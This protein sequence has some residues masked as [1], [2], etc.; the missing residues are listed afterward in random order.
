MKQDRI[1]IV[2]AGVAGINAATKLVDNGYPGELTAS[3]IYTEYISSSVLFVTGS[4]K[5]G[6]ETSDK[7]EFTGSVN[8]KDTLFLAGEPLGNSQLNEFTAS[9]IQQTNTISIF[10]ASVNFTTQSLN[11]QTGSQD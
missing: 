7:H 4:N 11:I 2:G 1:V 5:I 6:D 9:L 8:I 10:T 3:K